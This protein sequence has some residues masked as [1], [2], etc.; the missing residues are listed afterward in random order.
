MTTLM[1][2]PG[3]IATMTSFSGNIDIDSLK[4]HIYTVQKTELK[5]ILGIALYTKIYD[6][7]VAGTLAGLYKTIYDEFVADIIVYFSCM[8]YLDFGQFKT[9]NNGVFKPFAEGSNQ[10]SMQEIG[11]LLGR[12]RQLGANVELQFYE[13][14]KTISIPE[15]DSQQETE[16]DNIIPWY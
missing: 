15:Y 5:R 11:V 9:T 6:E 4:P 3:Y 13:Y 16:T 2:E 7:Y 12:Y 10:P 1:I 8:N 14:M